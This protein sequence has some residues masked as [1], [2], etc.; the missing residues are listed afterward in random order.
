MNPH[1]KYMKQCLELAWKGFGKVAPNPMVGCVI[2]YKNKV[3]GEGYHHLYGGAHAEVNAI[4]SVKDKSLLKESIL[5]VNLEPCSHFGKTP[6]CA[7]LIIRYKIKYVIIG[8]MDPNPLVCGKGIHKLVAAG[9]DVKVG[10]MEEEC[11]RVNRRFFSFYE[12]KRP[13]VILKWAQTADGYMGKAVRKDSFGEGIPIAIGRQKADGKGRIQITGAKAQK[14]VHKWR[15]EEQAIMVG[16]NTALVDN[17]HLT[18]RHLKGKNPVRVVIDRDL[19]IPKS[20]NL[21][22]RKVPTLVFTS[23]EKRSDKNIEYV[24]IDFQK[25]ILDQIL[26]ELHK[27]DIHSLIVEGGAKLL[28]SF[29][30]NNLWEEARVFTGTKQFAELQTNEKGVKAPS[31]EGEIVHESKE[32]KDTLKVFRNSS[33]SSQ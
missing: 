12:K 4:N 26:T 10:V 27:R 6:P 9:C 17:P 25:D 30:D 21:F 32:G 33:S 31:I 24:T 23:K 13:C 8:C 2:V 19:K 22:N 3:I 29:I 7:D 15:S 18:V 14:L 1:E 20:F 11:R 5:Y 16:T 28:N